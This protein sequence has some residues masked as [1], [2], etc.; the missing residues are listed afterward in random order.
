MEGD[1]CVSLCAFP[2]RLCLRIFIR[3]LRCKEEEAAKFVFDEEN[4]DI[5]FNETNHHNESEATSNCLADVYD[6]LTVYENMDSQ[7]LQQVFKFIL[8][9]LL[10]LCAIQG[11]V[12]ILAWGDAI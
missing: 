3:F 4:S 11:C 8:Y 5:N 1:S 6:D 9:V 12:G 2:L 10:L 7:T